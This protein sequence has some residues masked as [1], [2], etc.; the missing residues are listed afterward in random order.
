MSRGAFDD[1]ARLAERCT[2]SLRAGD[3]EAFARRL[4]ERRDVIARL[5]GATAPDGGAEAIRRAL[6]DDGRALALLD[7][8]RGRL[9]SELAALARYGASLRSYRAATP[10]RR[11]DRRG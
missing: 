4:E 7:A 5:A 9:E 11:L 6:G 8:A 2:L 10:S 1:L 3:W